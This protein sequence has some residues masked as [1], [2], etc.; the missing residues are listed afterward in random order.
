MKPALRIA[1]AVS[2]L[3]LAA[4]GGGAEG[5]VPV[6]TKNDSCAWCRMSVSDLRFAAQLTA[7]GHEPKLF[8]DA[9]CLRD[10]LKEPRESAPWTAWLSDHR[11]KEWVKAT[12]AVVVREPAIQTP[13]DSG[14]VAWASAASR[15]QDPAGK[16]GTP[17]PIADVIGPFTPG[18]K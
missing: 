3:L 8:D 12:D 1:A 2:I 14:L 16:G 13:M 7:P 5:P 10:W 6:D 15:E 18:V 9:G 17:V 4:C 11:T